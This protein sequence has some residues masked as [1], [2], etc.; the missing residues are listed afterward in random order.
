MGMKKVAVFLVVAVVCLARI[1]SWGVAADNILQFS[2]ITA[3][4]PQLQVE[5]KGSGFAASAISASFGGEALTVE[6]VHVYDPSQD[7]T[8]AYLLIDLSTSMEYGNFSFLKENVKRYINS[9]GSSDRVVVLTFGE[10][11]VQTLLTG[12]E[13]KADM[14]AA[15]DSLDCTEEGTL[16]YE[17]LSTAYQMATASQ[18]TYD[19]TYAIAFSDGVDYQ[20]GN[21]TYEEVLAS[22]QSHLLPLYAA[23]C[24]NASK[25]A[26]DRF[27]ELTRASGGELV[28]MYNE[29]DFDTLLSYI[30]QVTLVRLLATSSVADGQEKLLMIQ[31]NGMQASQSV[32][33]LFSMADAV[34]PTVSQVH[35]D[36][37]K[38]A[39]VIT[40]S[41]AVSGAMDPGAYTVVDRSG[42]AV[43]VLSVAPSQEA[44]TVELKLDG[45]KN[46][47]YAVRFNGITDL[48]QPANLLEGSVDFI[49][50]NI[51]E[52]SQFGSVL[53]IVLIFLI[54]VILV[55]ILVVV[56]VMQK[57]KPVNTMPAIP[58]RYEP[59]QPT[60]PISAPELETPQPTEPFRHHVPAN[61]LYRIQLSI[62][63]GSSPARNLELTISSS[64][65]VG[66]SSTC[67]VYIDDM[68]LSRQHFI[69]EQDD[70]VFYV[71]DLQ[72]KNGTLLNGNRV[73]SRQL[74]RS[75]D[76]IT[77]GLSD[78]MFKYIGR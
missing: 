8:C 67:D 46:G 31:A 50:Q 35:Y 36:A 38:D 44:N 43:E 10:T 4:M 63:N 1:L 51:Q 40:F 17:A 23:C 68:K 33:V 42:D 27:G 21:T 66:R 11:Q 58:V 69:I 71:M 65:V 13:S 70:G 30:N 22:Y 56:L 76:V 53:V 37:E 64:L 60:E 72:S 3:A 62:R 47:E 55:G 5:L 77:A 74:L 19:R 75:G 52:S 48:S 16:F 32:P 24:T 29:D 54:V 73:H 15:I 41:E 14:L 34:P 49:A 7:T 45:L 57:G 78:I 59:P 18:S 25:E 61:N 2:Q 6:D 26:A 12:D 28:F 9:M 20:K 39:L